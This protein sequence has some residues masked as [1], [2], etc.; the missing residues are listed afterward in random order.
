VII[1]YKPQVFASEKELGDKIVIIQVR[2]HVTS[3]VT[4]YEPSDFHQSLGHFF[5]D[6]FTSLTASSLSHLKKK[7]SRDKNCDYYI[8]GTRFYEP[9]DFYQSWDTFF[10]LLQIQILAASSLRI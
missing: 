8:Q 7:L 1:I 4:F 9:S 6:C 10:R 5:F 3:D 2:V